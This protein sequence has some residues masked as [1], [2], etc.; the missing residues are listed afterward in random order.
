MEYS[1]SD[2]VSALN[3]PPIDGGFFWL[4]KGVNLCG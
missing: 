4:K 3:E 2:K 1:D